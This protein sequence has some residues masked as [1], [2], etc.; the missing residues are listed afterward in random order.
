MNQ[1]LFSQV[2]H[3]IHKRLCELWI[4]CEKTAPIFQIKKIS[5]NIRNKKVNFA[6]VLKDIDNPDS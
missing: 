4:T 2:I 5:I 6:W 1:K 3:N